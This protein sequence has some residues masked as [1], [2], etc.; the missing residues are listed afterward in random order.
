L[1]NQARI[2]LISRLSFG[3]RGE[4]SN[5]TEAPGAMKLGCGVLGGSG[6]LLM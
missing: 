2:R 4:P 6:S 1:R 5:G 3:F